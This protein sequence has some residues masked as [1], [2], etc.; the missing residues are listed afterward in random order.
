MGQN[1]RCVCVYQFTWF[2]KWCCK[3][4]NHP[5]KAHL[6]AMWASSW[7]PA[8]AVQLSCTF[9]A[10]EQ[11]EICPHLC[12]TLS[13]L[14][15]R[16]PLCK[17]WLASNERIICAINLSKSNKIYVSFTVNESWVFC[18]VKGARC[19][20]NHLFNNISFNSY[21]KNIACLVNVKGFKVLSKTWVVPGNERS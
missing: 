13:Y 17:L 1:Q 12:N 8:I 20:W 9:L 2:F 14:L 4:K 3:K 6:R 7:C 19:T 5:S 11:W 16:F 21:S 18:Q 15:Y 10:K